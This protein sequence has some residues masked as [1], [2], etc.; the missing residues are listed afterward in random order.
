MEIEIINDREIIVNG[1]LSKDEFFKLAR[2]VK[3]DGAGDEA[4][5]EK[6]VLWAIKQRTGAECLNLLL[7]DFLTIDGWD[8]DEPQFGIPSDD[9]DFPELLD[10]SPPEVRR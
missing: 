2:I 8:G 4:D 5:V 3:R 6:L 1:V 7:E 10:F 9:E